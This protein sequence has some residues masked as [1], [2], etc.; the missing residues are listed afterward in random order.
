MGLRIKNKLLILFGAIIF[1]LNAFS[2]TYKGELVHVIYDNYDQT[3]TTEI[4]LQQSDLTMIKLPK[5]EFLNIESGSQISIEA[6]IISGRVQNI[7]KVK[8]LSK[9]RP[10]QEKKVVKQMVV[11]VN[12]SDV[13][14]P[15]EM[16]QELLK[17]VYIEDD[18]SIQNYYHQTSRGQIKFDFDPDGDGNLAL[19]GPIEIDFKQK[20]DIYSVR[21]KAN[22]ALKKIGIDSSLYTHHQYV[23]PQ[24]NCPFWGVAGGTDSWLN[25]DVNKFL[26][27]HESGHTLGLN[28]S[29]IKFGDK[30]GDKTCPMGSGGYV[31]YN[32]AHFLNFGW[33]SRT[34]KHVQTI[35]ESK[36]YTIAAQDILEDDN[37]EGP[38]FL[39]YPI[40]EIDKVLILSF[41]RPKGWDKNLKKDYHNKVLVHF[42]SSSYKG[43][44]NWYGHFGLGETFIKEGDGFK[45]KVVE[46]AD[47]FSWAKVEVELSAPSC[48]YKPL[49]ISVDPLEQ[50]LTNDGEVKYEVTMLNENGGTCEEYEVSTSVSHRYVKGRIEGE[51][52]KLLLPGEQFSYDFYASSSSDNVTRDI[53]FNASYAKSVT[54]KLVV[55]KSCV[56][57]APEFVMTPESYTMTDE[58]DALFELSIKNNDSSS[59]PSRT[60][61]LSL[62]IDSKLEG[63]I[64]ESSV[65][66]SPGETR[67]STVK[68]KN[69]NLNGEYPIRVLNNGVVI[70]E[71]SLKVDIESCTE[72]ASSFKLDPQEAII[73]DDQAAEFNLTVENNDSLQCDNKN[74]QLNF[75]SSEDLS[76]NLSELNFTL[77]P[78]KSKTIKFTV[79]GDYKKGS[80]GFSIKDGDNEV[81]SGRIVFNRPV[82]EKI[83]PTWNLNPNE[84]IITDQS[85]AKF[86]I[87]VTNGDTEVCEKRSFNLRSQGDSQLKF[88]F[89][90][91]TF[92]LNPGENKKVFLTVDSDTILEGT[93]LID[94]FDQNKNVLQGR[95]V[96]DRA[97]EPCEAKNFQLRWIE[98]SLTLKK[99]ESGSIKAVVKNMNPEHC[100]TNYKVNFKANKLLELSESSLD[101]DL[102][103]GEEKEV[104]ALVT[105]VKSTRRPRMLRLKILINGRRYTSF[106]FTRR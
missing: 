57:N 39:T 58:K 30:Y 53:T 79:N 74:Y 27:S 83:D 1:C 71:S 87:S 76:S 6:K 98:R 101:F 7:D 14:H 13:S 32:S 103:S 96:Y 84:I 94:I 46:F 82:C 95:L 50:I 100:T 89:S 85:S 78:Q 59:C 3:S 104:E 12:F 86:E 23:I 37:L 90:E 40:K 17:K 54:A 5:S 34:T 64:T 105:L 45:F 99:G 91:E 4:Y 75:N 43:L 15:P 48:E 38:L 92:D 36:V 65:S 31:Q 18:D 11:L 102:E 66:I 26:I 28:H 73:I 67:K 47:D 56:Q 80:Y 22:E 106:I 29:K 25:R 63:S 21:R 44:P 52:S 24:T 10:Y 41:K 97:P 8:V 62:E 55:K 61:D 35:T 49:N 42:T 70:A 72:R 51:T 2:K 16:N 60:L 93:Y 9:P 20:C 69:S 33:P 68:I 81:S 88:N 77:A 19:L